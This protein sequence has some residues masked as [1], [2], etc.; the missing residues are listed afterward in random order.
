[1]EVVEINVK[2]Y[3]LMMPFMTEILNLFPD[4]TFIFTL[5]FNTTI[6]H[7]KQNKKSSEYINNIDLTNKPNF[8]E[9]SKYEINNIVTLNNI[10]K[11]FDNSKIFDN[12]IIINKYLNCFD[13]IIKN[14]DCKT[15][16]FV[17]EILF[18]KFKKLLIYYRLLFIR[19]CEQKD[20]IEEINNKQKELLRLDDHGN[21]HC[22]LNNAFSSKKNNSFY[23]KDQNDNRHINEILFNQFYQNYKII[24]EIVH[25]I[26]CFLLDCNENKMIPSFIN[27]NE[28]DNYNIKNI[29]DISDNKI[30]LHLI[31]YDP[32]S[33]FFDENKKICHPKKIQLI[34]NNHK[35]KYRLQYDEIDVDKSIKKQKQKIT[36][37]HKNN[38]DNK[39]GSEN[40]NIIIQ[41]SGEFEKPK[42]KPKPVKK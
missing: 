39:K 31:N 26:F 2:D 37:I 36:M 21:G 25:Y 41:S 32:K 8:Y 29:F 38:I 1:M 3:I 18:Y 7:F 6:Q 22:E 24:F 34:F 40:N 20:K 42:K 4:G 33:T 11:I 10:P 5:H 15:I 28:Y 13:K 30:T 14:V 16:G 19:M 27:T 23:I 12:N 17:D 35:K 9:E